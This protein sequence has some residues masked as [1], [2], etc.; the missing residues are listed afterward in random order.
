MINQQM[1]ALGAAPNKIRE[2]FMY[3]LG[4]KAEIGADNVYDY[5]IGNPSVPAPDAVREAFLALLE[6]DPVSVHE[7]TPSPGDPAV[8]AAIAEHI[9]R[10]F[11]VEAAAA[12]VYVTSGA[13]SAIAITFCAVCQPGD[14]IITPSPYFPEYKT[15]AHTAQCKLVEVPVLEPSFQLDVDAIE[16]A[17]TPRT[18][19]IIINTPNNPV[20][21]VYPAE[22]LERLAEVLRRKGDEFG[23]TIYLVSDEPYREIVYGAEVPYIPAIYTDTIVCY[24]WSKS[25]SLP[26]ERIG[27]I[28]VN[29][30]IGNAAEISTAVSGAGRALGYICAPVLLQRVVARCL[31][32]P[33]DVAE[34][35]KNR[36]ILTEMLREIGYEFVEPDGAFYLWMRA[37]EPD[38]QAFSDRAKEHEL[39][40]VPSDSFGC[41][42]W[43]R[44]SYC[45]AESTIRASRGVLQALWDSYHAPTLTCG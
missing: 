9:S 35:A 37:L 41:A 43:V 19:A 5:S 12:N 36:A 38:A 30:A 6:D 40:L 45:I 8:R 39:L 16:R 34:Y 4:R 24:T 20:G 7:Y 15:W 32:V 22:A 17:I 23:R 13:S 33:A 26:G 42:G 2:L 27:Y 25:L 29:D 1:Y 44:L 14:E 10:R 11:G 18:S 21:A 28:H 3:G 31:D